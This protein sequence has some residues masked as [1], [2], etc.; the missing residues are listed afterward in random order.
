MEWRVTLE[1]SGADG[2]MQTQE[3]ARGGTDSYSTLDP[4]GLTL[5]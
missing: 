5:N 1:L 4:L 2:T 3:V